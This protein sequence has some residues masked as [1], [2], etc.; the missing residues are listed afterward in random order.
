MGEIHP[1]AVEEFR[2]R[3]RDNHDWMK[4]LKHKELNEALRSIGVEIDRCDERLDKH[5]KVSILLGIMYKTFAFWLD[6]GL[7]KTRVALELLR[8]WMKMKECKIALVIAPSETILFGWE[9][10]IKRFKI[11]LP[12]ITL[13][14]SS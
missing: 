4:K 7:G 6:M 3:P 10:Q 1:R 5:Q 9:A 14:N 13:P 2:N 12:Y 11:K 8:Y